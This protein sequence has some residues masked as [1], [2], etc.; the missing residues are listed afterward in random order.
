MLSPLAVLS[1]KQ[2]MNLR[3]A[4]DLSDAG[5]QGF[6]SGRQPHSTQ[7][8]TSHGSCVGVEAV[9]PAGTTVGPRPSCL[10]AA[11]HMWEE[12]KG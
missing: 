11:P 2:T 10:E 5:S 1:S 12:E 3:S 7:N 8:L 6:S 4:P 9:T